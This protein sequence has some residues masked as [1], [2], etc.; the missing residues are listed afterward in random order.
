MDIPLASVKR[1]RG[2]WKLLE[3]TGDI[4]RC[5]ASLRYALN[6]KGGLTLRYRL[7]RCKHLFVFLVSLNRVR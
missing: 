5:L 6:P 1:C 7:W 4:D 2:F 3:A